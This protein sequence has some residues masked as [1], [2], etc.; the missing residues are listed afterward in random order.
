MARL[1]ARE[2]AA[3]RAALAASQTEASTRCDNLFIETM[4]GLLDCAET[5]LDGCGRSVGRAFLA[6]GD[7][8]HDNCCE[9]EGQ[10]WVRLIE[11]YPSAS[12]TTPFPAQATNA[13]PCGI[14]ILAARVAVGI[15]RCA[16]TLDDQ[17]N[18]PT[19]EELTFD[20]LGATADASILLS[21]IQCCDVLTRSP[22]QALR[23][24]RWTA[25]GPQGGCVGG[26]WELVLGLDNCGC[27]G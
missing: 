4:A 25:S 20:A 7:V 1:S 12:G 9:D 16:H 3:Q 13:Q 5:A 17:G 8:A 19:A 10:L 22:V 24:G 11:A 2:A 27:G 26:E 15:V 14:K 23:I 18:A 6:V 21:A